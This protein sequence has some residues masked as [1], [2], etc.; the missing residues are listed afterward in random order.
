MPKSTNKNCYLCGKYD[1]TIK[2]KGLP[3]DIV[4]TCKECRD[5]QKKRDEEKNYYYDD[6]TDSE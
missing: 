4:I 1:E 3:N 6:Y 2:P 5:A